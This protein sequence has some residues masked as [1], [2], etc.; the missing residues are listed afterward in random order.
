M[1]LSLYS[2]PFQ[3]VGNIDARAARRAIGRPTLD[4]WTIF[5]RETLQ[6]SWDARV[7]PEG[8]IGFSVDAWWATQRQKRALF[9]QVFA[10]QPPELELHELLQADDLGLL[11]I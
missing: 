9:E 8:H 1:A 10:Q 6:N 4:A 2:E 7:R 11:L 5:L 3:P